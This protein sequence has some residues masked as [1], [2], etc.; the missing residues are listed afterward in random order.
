MLSGLSAY[1]NE[2]KKAEEYKTIIHR[3]AIHLFF[4][5]YI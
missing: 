5:C 4:M 1:E 3:S 2:A